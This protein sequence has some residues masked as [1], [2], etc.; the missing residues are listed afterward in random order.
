MEPGV[1]RTRIEPASSDERFVSLRRQLRVTSFGF[2][3]MILTPGQRGRIHRHEHQ[4]EVYVV[5]EGTLT[6]IVE[7]EEQTLETGEV[8][9]V[10]PEV[11]RQLAN[12]G[13][14]RVMLLALGGAGE[15]LGRDGM[16]YA[17]WDSTEAKAPQEIPLPPD[18]PV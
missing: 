15:H 2:N 6:L 12:R 18:L 10:G 4:E 14:E 17:G 16:A 5:L 11:R 13:P 3:Q 9:R 8:V 1:A 7:G